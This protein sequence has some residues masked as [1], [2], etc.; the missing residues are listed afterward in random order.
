MVAISRDQ[1]GLASVLVAPEYK[2][3]NAARALKYPLDI[4]N[5][6]H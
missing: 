1:V 4:L 6:N 5:I 2:P 3:F